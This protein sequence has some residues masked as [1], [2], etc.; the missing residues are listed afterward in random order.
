MDMER[1]KL[2]FGTSMPT[3]NSS[4][5]K[6]VVVPRNDDRP[7]LFNF[8]INPV[9]GE[10]K[11]KIASKKFSAVEVDIKKVSNLLDFNNETE[12]NNNSTSLFENST[13]TNNTK[14][15]NLLDM[16]INTGSGF[17]GNY[18]SQQS[19]P[20]SFIDFNNIPVSVGNTSNTGN[21]NN[22]GN[23]GNFNMNPTTNT[24]KSDSLLSA[25]NSLPQKTV[26]SDQIDYYVGNPNQMYY[27]NLD[28]IN[29]SSSI[30]LNSKSNQPK[31]AFSDLFG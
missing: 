2:H 27:P 23:I 5:S 31:D 16:G 20:T 21:I 1:N 19:Q 12:K 28:K 11:M 24:N 22:I 9:H 6:T 15:V 10:S 13:V 18:V 3:C 8:K 25:L 29:Y 7:S 17:S 4:V 26:Q 30:P 14:T